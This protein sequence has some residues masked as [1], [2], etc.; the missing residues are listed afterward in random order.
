MT[1]M[2]RLM[3]EL[4]RHAADYDRTT[5]PEEKRRAL[6]Q[7]R[8]TFLLGNQSLGLPE[9]GT[10]E[11]EQW[12]EG[13]TIPFGTSEGNPTERPSVVVL[14]GSEQ[15]TV[16]HTTT[17]A[18]TGTDSGS[19]HSVGTSVSVGSCPHCGR[20]AGEREVERRSTTRTMGIGRSHGRSIT[21]SKDACTTPSEPHTGGENAMSAD[22]R[23]CDSV[24]E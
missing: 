5:A 10:V 19:S 22:G 1:G 11:S 13:G 8:I 24:T 18:G 15:E 23:D 17:H 20:R 3:E 9:S 4:R 16:T 14:T 2:Q 7:F 12:P 6:R 21:G